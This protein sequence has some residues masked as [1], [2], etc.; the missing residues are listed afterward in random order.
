[1][2]P[3]IKKEKDFLRLFLHTSDKQ[4]KVLIKNIEKSQLNAIVQIVYNVMLGIRPL[5]EKDKNRI[6]NRKTIIRQFVSKGI[7]LKRRK[8]LLFKH[9]KYILPFIAAVKNELL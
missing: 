4:K 5:A 8:E 7:S 9:F 3:L 2:N 1:M 6:A